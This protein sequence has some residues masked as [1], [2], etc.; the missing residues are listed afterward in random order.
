MD[1]RIDDYIINDFEAKVQF[2]RMTI[3][4]SEVTAIYQYTSFVRTFSFEN[5]TWVDAV[6]VTDKFSLGL[7]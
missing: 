7:N 5:E 4:N 3:F 2:N 6:D 1:A